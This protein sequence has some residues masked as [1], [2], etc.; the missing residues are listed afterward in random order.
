MIKNF[1]FKN[2][3]IK[4][5]SNAFVIPIYQSSTGN[6]IFA[7]LA[8]MGI[9]NG[10]KSLEKFSLRTLLDILFAFAYNADNSLVYEEFYEK[11]PLKFTLEKEFIEKLAEL[12]TKELMPEI[13]NDG[14]NNEKK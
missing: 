3:Q 7:D 12:I 10:N 8:K 11:I 5:K 14:D 13:K 2:F 9:D 4:I 6:D 1:N